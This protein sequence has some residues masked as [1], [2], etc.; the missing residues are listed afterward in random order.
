M[1]NLLTLS[2]ADV[3]FGFSFAS[4]EKIW[5]PLPSAETIDLHSELP[6]HLDD[7]FDLS[8]HLP[9]KKR[10]TEVINYRSEGET[11]PYLPVKNE[12]IFLASTGMSAIFTAFRL[13][14]L[15][16]NQ[17]LSTSGGEPPIFVV[18]GFLY[19]DTLKVMLRP[20]WNAGGVHFFGHGNDDDLEELEKLLDANQLSNTPSS[21]PFKNRVA[22][23]FSELPTNPLIN[24]ANVERLVTLFSSWI[25]LL[26]LSVVFS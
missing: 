12:D 8:T 10:I 21:S 4:V 1:T 7:D 26:F 24:C 5:A 3:A 9:I 18:F 23:I 22:A 2:N 14:Q 11:A 13:I 19:L 20:E 25:T 6:Y 16:Y 17:S 15:T